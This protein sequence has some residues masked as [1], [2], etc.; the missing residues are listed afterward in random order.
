M[1]GDFGCKETKKQKKQRIL[2][3]NIER[4]KRGE[5]KV[6][7]SIGRFGDKV[8]KQPYGPDFEVERREIFTGKV[9]KEFVEV[10]TGKA[11]LS[12]LQRKIRKKRKFKVE[13]V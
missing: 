7:V 5:L 3:E 13:R 12:P 1:F 11:K 9:T 4:G 10:K 8:T 6:K 2:R